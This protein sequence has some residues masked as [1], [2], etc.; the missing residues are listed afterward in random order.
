MLTSKRASLLALKSNLVLLVLV[1]T[2]FLSGCASSNHRDL[3]SQ[4]L[5][6]TL[7]ALAKRHRICGVAVAVVKD[8]KLDV[9][10]T[11]TG[12][13]PALPVSSD[14]VFQAA[15]LSKPVFAYAVLKLVA[16][17]KLELD[18]PVMKYLPKGYRH[19]FNPLKAEPSEL[20]TDPRLQAIT[21]RMVLN[22]T[23][24]LPSWAWGPLKFVSTPGTAWNYSGEGYFLLQ[25]AV[26]AVTNQPLDQFMSSQL[27]KPLAMNHSDFV[28]NERSSQTLMA[29]TKANGKPRATMELK[30]PNAAFSLHTTASDYGKF[31]VALLNDDEIIKQISASPVPVDPGLGVSWGLGWGIARDHDE[32]TIWQWGNNTGY[33]AFVIASPGTGDGFVMLTNSEN[34]LELAEPLTQKILPGERRLF[35][36]S[37]LHGDVINWVC[38]TVRLCL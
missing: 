1:I 22:H 13:S 24:G 36:F 33:R 30:E 18:A 11:A 15:S 25:R 20:V 31:L 37:S 28:W 9:I 10:D 34:G 14:S 4:S 38:N 27:F 17:G 26:E 2:I 12:C 8:R 16:Q 21:V 35:Q 3:T 29:G 7:G 5:H 19:Q 32:S 23:A 6:E